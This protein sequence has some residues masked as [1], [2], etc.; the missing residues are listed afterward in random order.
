M[1]ERRKDYSVPRRPSRTGFTFQ[2]EWFHFVLRHESAREWRCH[3]P[4]HRVVLSEPDA[5][6]VDSPRLGL[7]LRSH[8]RRGG[9]LAGGARC[10][11]ARP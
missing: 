6:E 10:W 1:S 5:T 4:S 3:A 9:V 8:Y 2:V 7:P 11:V